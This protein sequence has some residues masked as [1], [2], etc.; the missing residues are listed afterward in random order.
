MLGEDAV[1]QGLRQGCV[2]TPLLFN[3]FFV[4]DIN[5]VF[6]PFKVDK[7]TMMYTMV[8]LSKK[9]G[10]GESNYRRAS[11]SDIALG[12]TLR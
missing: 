6:M 4:A 11:P 8:H 5:V 3:T 9:T 2:L 1:E 12:H 10:A 7:N